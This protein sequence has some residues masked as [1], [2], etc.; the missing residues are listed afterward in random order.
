M[1]RLL[2]ILAS[3]EIILSLVMGLFTI[4]I[5]LIL[6]QIVVIK[7]SLEE[8]LLSRNISIGIFLGSV[9]FGVLANVNGS[10]EPAVNLLQTKMMGQGGFSFSVFI[11]SLL[12]FFVFYIISFLITFFLLFAT[13]KVG[14]SLTK[15]INEIEEITSGNAA[16]TIALAFYIIGFCY[17]VR[18]ATKNFVGSLVNYE[19]VRADLENNR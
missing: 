5:T 12:Q 16:I 2:I 17:F 11:G 4:M 9:V 8:M 13:L 6:I 10:I 1:D 7:K 19:L 14:F 3:Y 15:R 18:P